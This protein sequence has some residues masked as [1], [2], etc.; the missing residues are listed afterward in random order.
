MTAMRPG[1]LSVGEPLW[2]TFLRKKQIEANP[3]IHVAGSRRLKKRDYVVGDCIKLDIAKTDRGR[4]TEVV[5]G[6]FNHGITGGE[7]DGV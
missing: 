7:R 3:Q 4:K 6:R 2:L 1:L 5:I